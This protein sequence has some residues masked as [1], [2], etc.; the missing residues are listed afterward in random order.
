[1][2]FAIPSNMV[3]AVLAQ[4]LEHG[5]VERGMLGVL[6]QNISPEIAEALN[7]KVTDGALVTDTVPGS[8]AEAADIQ[9][10]DI[11]KKVN[12]I[13]IKSAEQLR[14]T[15]GLMRPG[16]KVNLEVERNHKAITLNAKMGNPNKIA[17]PQTPFLGGMRIE[18][19]SQLQPDGTTLKGAI[20]VT[21]D[22]NSDAALAGLA[23]GDIVVT[24]NGNS[25]T[26]V[27]QLQDI[28]N[29]KPAH[30]LLKI[31]RDNAKLFVVIQDT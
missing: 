8:P 10:E 18:D 25:I 17:Q 15:L 30:L 11:I 27:K 16:T 23:P 9:P 29:Q 1:V 14:N 22:D 20:V 6:A 28:A 19:F 13:I 26:S 21:V 31:V 5:K 24:A 7:M 3:H 12:G 2:G 4:L